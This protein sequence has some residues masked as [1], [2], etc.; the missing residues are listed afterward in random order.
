MNHVPG[1]E[2]ANYEVA[3][4]GGSVDDLTKLF[5]GAKVV[6][7]TVGPFIYNG[8]RVIEAALKADCHY[9]DI[10]GEQAWLR[11]VSEKWGDK[12]AAQGSARSSGYS[13]HVAQSAMPPHG[14]ASRLQPSTR[15]RSS[16]CSGVYPRLDRRKQF[17]LS[18]PR[19]PTTSSKIS[20]NPGREQGAM[21]W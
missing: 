4:V 3:E 2:T 16:P 15:L 5:T 19:K 11:E 21:R 18:F 17:L 7:N 12:F 14:F 8:P 13:V 10:G 9:L 20:T 1:I 6:C